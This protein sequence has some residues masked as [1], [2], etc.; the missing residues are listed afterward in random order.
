MS[1]TAGIRRTEPVVREVRRVLHAQI[2]DAHDALQGR[3]VS[4]RAVHTARKSIKKARSTLRLMRDGLSKA[5][6]ERENLALRD[7]GR[8]LSATRDARI[9]VDALARLA[10]RYGA[11]AR[12]PAFDGLRRLL[13]SERRQ[14]S[15]KGSRNL[16]GCRRALR[17]RIEHPSRLA[18]H[19][20]GWLVIAAG[21]TR[22]YARGRRAGIAARKDSSAERLHE[23]RKQVKD[24]A[25][26]LT[27]LEPA[28][29][30]P[31]GER[32]DQASKLSDY[33]G[34]DHDLAVLR[35]KLLAHA[36]RFADAAGTR[37]LLALI[38]RCRKRLQAKAFVLGERIYE[39]KSGAFVKRL[40]RYWRRWQRAGP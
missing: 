23:W 38:D 20:D 6:Y 35:E 16:A 36:E 32:V 25:H 19:G 2:S 28:W 39:E 27:L 21:L 15:R 3:R 12:S 40:G 30:G 1:G 33:L 18:G 31:L 24:L 4:D 7:A 29:P 13:E 14:I 17:A 11:A 10:E 26:Q 9:L 37:A 8:S 22:V 5:A 34:D